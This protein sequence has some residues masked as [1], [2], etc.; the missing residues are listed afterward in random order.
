MSLTNANIVQMKVASPLK[1]DLLLIVLSLD[2]LQNTMECQL[3][4]ALI[5]NFNLIFQKA[6]LRKIHRPLIDDKWYL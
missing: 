6:E 1:L 2:T 3:V 4:I 5:Y